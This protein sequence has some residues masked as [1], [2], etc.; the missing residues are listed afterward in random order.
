MRSGW[1][2]YTILHAASVLAPGDQ[3]A[4][5]REEW[6]SE[7]WYI[8]RGGATRFCLGAFRDAMWLRRNN[9]NPELGL[10]LESPLCCLAWLSVVAAAG[11]WLA[12]CL[13]RPLKL[14]PLYSGLG[15]RDL[16]IGCLAM[17]G[18]SCLLLPGTLAVWRAPA[19]RA[20][21]PWGSRLR[22]GMFLALKVALV[23]P[24]LLCV[25]MVWILI[26]PVAPFAPYG[27]CAACIL[28]LR[29]VLIDQQRRCPVCLQWLT[30]PVRIGA[31]SRTFLEWY[32]AETTCARGHGLLHISEMPPSYCRRAHWLWLDD[33]WSDLFPRASR[34]RS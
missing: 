17:L 25:F 1:L 13:S 3:R 31:P 5:F 28:T 26:A 27:L 9:L 19:R 21:T 18:L 2:Q 10:P 15:A 8:P 30:K 24:I 14:V 33:S 29:W 12:V 34:R 32:G 4:N 20:G 23:Q 16:P 7:L 22:A 11:L 6:R